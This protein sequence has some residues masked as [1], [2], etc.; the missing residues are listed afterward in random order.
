LS[1]ANRAW[2]KAK[3]EWVGSDNALRSRL[4]SVS[5]DLKST[6]ADMSRLRNSTVDQSEFNRAR[7]LLVA[8]EKKVKT[9][10][11]QLKIRDAEISKL[12]Q[13]SPKSSISMSP[14]RPLISSLETQLRAAQVELTTRDQARKKLE[15]EKTAMTDAI[16]AYHQGLAA[17]HQ[18]INSQAFIPPLPQSGLDAS[19]FAD[20]VRTAVLAF[21]QKRP[22]AADDQSI[23][24]IENAR[25]DAG[26]L[27]VAV[28]SPS[29]PGRFY[30]LGN[31]RL[32]IRDGSIRICIK[33]FREQPFIVGKV[34]MKQSF[35]DF[36]LLDIEPVRNAL[37]K[38]TLGMY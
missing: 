11:E 2:K 36:F 25:A 31:P 15:L 4:A 29:E 28:A 16:Q 7:E 22:A 35:G 12:Q 38:A 1:E 30:I 14:D 26:D 19:R 27:V 33:Y 32:K 20:A 37:P 9:C 18:L 34:V 21:V 8:S 5:Y 6:Q 24:A 13:S 3:E 17:I 23:L 10:E